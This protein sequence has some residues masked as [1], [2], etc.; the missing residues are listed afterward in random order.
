VFALRLPQW[1][2]GKRMTRTVNE[3]TGRPYAT[4]D[5]DEVADQMW[6]SFS[7]VTGWD[8]GANDGQSVDRMLD[9]GFG[10]V[11]ALEPADESY[12]RLLENWG[13]DTRVTLL[14]LAA[15][16]HDGSMDLSVRPFP[17]SSSGQLVAMHMPDEAGLRF[18]QWWDSPMGKREVQSVTL[19]TLAAERGV[20]D[21]VKI[22]TEGGEELIL[23]GASALLATRQPSWLIEFHSPKL[24][25][26][27]T[28]ILEAGGYQVDWMRNPH[29]VADHDDPELDV[30]GWIQARP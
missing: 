26:A 11:V 4:A 30:N 21:L 9:L 2:A 5:L 27:C 24:R 8:V 6:A 23:R 1:T 29:D 16:D 18:S 17:I 10:Y 20:P 12:A 14:C 28:A 25:R 3:H 22:D 15:S 7:G 19:D 13:H